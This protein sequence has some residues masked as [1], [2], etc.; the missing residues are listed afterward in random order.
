MQNLLLLDSSPT[1]KPTRIIN[2]VI[3]EIDNNLLFNEILPENNG[4]LIV[5]D[6]LKDKKR[7]KGLLKVT[8][9]NTRSVKSNDKNTELIPQVER[10]MTEMTELSAHTVKSD[11]YQT[12]SDRNPRLNTHTVKSNDKMDKTYGLSAKSNEKV[13]RHN[14]HSVKSNSEFYLEQTESTDETVIIFNN[15]LYK[16][17]SRRTNKEYYH[18]YFNKNK[19]Q[20]EYI[21]HSVKSNGNMAELNTHSVKSHEKMT[22]LML[23]SVINNE[24]T[25]NCNEKTGLNIHSV[26]SNDEMT[27]YITHNAKNLDGNDKNYGLCGLS[28]DKNEEGK[29][30]DKNAEFIT[31]SVKSNEYVVYPPISDVILREITDIVLSYDVHNY[32][33]ISTS[34]ISNNKSIQYI[35]CISSYKSLYNIKIKIKIIYILSVIN[36]ENILEI[37]N[38]YNKIINKIGKSNA[39]SGLSLAQ[40][41]KI[42]DKNEISVKSNNKSA[43]YITHGVKSNDKNIEGGKSS[44]NLNYLLNDMHYGVISLNNCRFYY[45][46]IYH[47]LLE[48]RLLFIS[49]NDTVLANFIQTIIMSIQPFK[50]KGILL[51]N[52]TGSYRKLK[53][54]TIPYILGMT[55]FDPKN[56]PHKTVIIFIDENKIIISENQ[57]P[58]ITKFISKLYN[59]PRNRKC[60]PFYNEIIR[61]FS[62]KWPKLKEELNIY[63]EILMASI[64]NARDKVIKALIKS[65]NQRTLKDVINNDKFHLEILKEFQEC[66]EFYRE[67]METSLYQEGIHDARIKKV[68]CLGVSQKDLLV[69]LWIF[70][71]TCRECI[72]PTRNLTKIKFVIESYLS[73]FLVSS[74][75]AA[76]TLLVGL[77]GILS[78]F[79]LFGVIFVVSDVLLGRGI[80]ISEEMCSAFMPAIESKDLLI[81]QEKDSLKKKC[82]TEIRLEKSC[83]MDYFQIWEEISFTHENI[84]S[85]INRFICASE[86]TEEDASIM[87]K[88]ISGFD[89][90]ELPY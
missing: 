81:L 74:Y 44:D 83:D 65:H 70:M 47:T 43:E 62:G 56:I 78:Y 60:M 9:L 5:F 13:A 58:E 63:M 21:T 57:R 4:N 69:I 19:M 48:H 24:Y 82:I 88:V 1:G 15:A 30:N 54:T 64:L 85:T 79:D 49:K 90:Y 51:S 72:K 76:D 61:K 59:T 28:P 17:A 10:V 6:I 84:L 55:K 23:H 42:N 2:I 32:T 40:S 8:R 18:A 52:A 34:I 16:I 38:I 12:N 25:A 3:T 37:I 73:Q 26:I 27:E 11:E 66:Q 77:F 7:M 75:T 20:I 53:E 71:S 35:L 87:Q 45:D 39:Q 80:E 86:W 22:R 67:F 68:L 50:W 46:I 14:A 31:H 36:T 89:M 29:S 41:G 33:S